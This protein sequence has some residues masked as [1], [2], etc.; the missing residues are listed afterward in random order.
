M[1]W[2]RNLTYPAQSVQLNSHMVEK[3]ITQD[4]VVAA[5][6]RL[7][8]T[9]GGYNEIEILIVGEVAGRLNG[10][11]PRQETTKDC[12]VMVYDP[13]NAFANVEHEA[14]KVAKEA[15]LPH[16][17]LNS[18]AHGFDWALPHDWKT[19]RHELGC[20]GLLKVFYIDRVDFVALK[21]AASRDV[22]RSHLTK[23]KLNKKDL[24]FAKQHIDRLEA[25][26][27]ASVKVQ[28]ARRTIEILEEQ[29]A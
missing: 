10:C 5:F 17:W 8:E 1:G 9:V 12:D 18:D 24:Q 16:K 20:F 29:A 19:R 14:F 13:E 25:N 22:D 21:V 6:H 26:G 2:I 4:A 28:A 3:Y 11:L 15:G 7:G 27:L 23:M